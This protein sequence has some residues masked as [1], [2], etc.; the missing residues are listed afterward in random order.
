MINYSGLIRSTKEI[1]C[2]KCGQ[3]NYILKYHATQFACN[4]VIHSTC[5]GEHLHLTCS[6]GWD[7][8]MPTKESEIDKELRRR[9][10]ID[11]QRLGQDSGKS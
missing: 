1:Y 8:T 11:K 7:W 2:I 3:S 9:N 5:E 4:E 6:C 10:E